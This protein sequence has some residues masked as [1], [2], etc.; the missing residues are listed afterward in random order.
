MVRLLILCS[1]LLTV[2]TAET[3]D[4]FQQRLGAEFEQIF[5]G[6]NQTTALWLGVSDPLFGDLYWVFGNSRISNSSSDSTAAEAFDVPATLHDHFDIGSISKTFGGT[7]HLLLIE[8]GLF[9]LEDTVQDIV[10]DFVQQFPVIGNYTVRELLSM[11]TLI[12][13]F[14]NEPGSLFDAGVTADPSI[15]Y[16][17]PEIIGFAVQNGL[18]N[19]SNDPHAGYYSTTNFLIIEYIAEYVT[20]K[21]M[22]DLVEELILMPLNLS[23]TALPLRNSSGIQ[24]APEA[25]SYSSDVCDLSG[26]TESEIT[27]YSRALV[28]T[29]SGGGMYSTITDLLQWAKSGTGDSL[30]SESTIEQRHNYTWDINNIALYGLAQF[31]WE[32]SAPNFQELAVFDGWYGHNGQVL[33]FDALAFKNKN[34]TASFV[35][36][37]NTCN[38]VFSMLQ[39]WAIYIAELD[40]RN[41]TTIEQPTPAPTGRITPSTVPPDAGIIPST[42]PAPS[43]GVPSAAPSP[44]AVTPSLVT[45]PP[46]SSNAATPGSDTSGGTVPTMM[47]VFASVVLAASAI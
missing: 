24:P 30:L 8:E 40:S 41:A 45:M 5:Q 43:G 3:V 4:E 28:Q 15:R 39:A 16:T 23:N 12:P 37:S 47:Y 22:S 35:G 29:G 33:D 1:A 32:W 42:V 11:K 19:A 13:D 14:L 2:A 21:S 7:V 26:L 6:Q 36:G 10:P 46:P 18:I 34:N 9:N 38:Y 17:I 31:E 44:A 25:L 27:D 20:G